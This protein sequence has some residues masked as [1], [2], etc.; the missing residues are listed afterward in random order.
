MSEKMLSTF[1]EAVRDIPDGSTI[2]LGGFGPGTPWNLIRALYQQ[3][4]RDL[5]LVC[6]SGSGGAAASGGAD[7]VTHQTLIAAGRV[8]KVIASFTASTHPSRKTALD[9]MLESG[10]LEAELVPQGTLAERIR[11]GGAGIPA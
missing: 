5:T 11:A 7:L 1:A 8:R 10:Q 6:N 3:G 4:A 2:L 9:E